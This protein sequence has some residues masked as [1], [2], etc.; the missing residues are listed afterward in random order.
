[1]SK[2]FVVTG[3]DTD[4]GKT[5]ASAMLVQALGADYF[6]P[7]QAGLEGEI[8]SEAVKRLSGADDSRIIPELYRLTTPASPHY[9][10]DIDGIVIDIEDLRVPPTDKPLIVEGA[11]GLLV[12][13]NH[14]KLL[15]EAFSAWGHPAILVARTALGTINHSLLSIHLMNSLKIPMHG[16][17]FVGDANPSSEEA[18]CKFGEVRCLGR[19]PY[20]EE[21]SAASLQAV[22]DSEFDIEDFQ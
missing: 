10:A 11:G 7:I 20:L 19:I 17:I 3:T 5:V 18:I 21:L 8:D 1:M 9:A 14:E 15:A 16:I 4:V 13:V 6:K 2:V 12:P 22:F